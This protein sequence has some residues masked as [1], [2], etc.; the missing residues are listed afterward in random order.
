LRRADDA[1]DD[2]LVLD[3]DDGDDDTWRAN[4]NHNAV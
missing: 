3:F 1:D 4:A 2:S